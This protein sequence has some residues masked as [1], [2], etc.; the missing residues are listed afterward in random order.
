[1]TWMAPSS[2]T[3]KRKE[4]ER[5]L[6]CRFANSDFVVLFISFRRFVYFI[7]S[8]CRLP[9]PVLSFCLFRFVALFILFRRFVVLSNRGLD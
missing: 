4:R 7:P 9:T 5:R 8:F 1:M 2:L 6:V 3:R